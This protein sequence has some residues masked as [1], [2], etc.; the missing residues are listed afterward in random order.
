MAVKKVILSKRLQMLAD[1]VKR[2]DRVADVGCDHGFLSIYLVQQGISP[3]VL[4][5]DVRRGPLSAA[6]E[7]IAAYGLDAYITVRLSDGV[8]LME[9]GEADTVVCAGM[10]GALMQRIL[11]EGMEKLRDMTLILQPQSELKEFRGFLRREGF[12][13]LEENAVFEEGKYYFAMKTVF[14]QESEWQQDGKLN[15]EETLCPE[16]GCELF[17]E[18]GELLLKQKHP[19]LKQYLNYRS[20]IL[21]QLVLSLTEHIGVHAGDEENVKRLEERLLQVKKELLGIDEALNWYH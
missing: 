18:Y 10:G 12:R 20:D 1:M 7:H 17:E 5:M 2:G 11:K 4:A 8:T 3:E 9:K 21:K 19:I 14:T 16:T 13:I 6:K 15:R